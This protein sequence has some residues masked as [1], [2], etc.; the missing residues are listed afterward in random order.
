MMINLNHSLICFVTIVLASISSK[1][2]H[3]WQQDR[4]LINVQQYLAILRSCIAAFSV[5]QQIDVVLLFKLHC[6]DLSSIP[7]A[8]Q[9]STKPTTLLVQHELPSPTLRAQ[10]GGHKQRNATQILSSTSSLE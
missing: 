6:A 9:G 5:M 1:N 10:A 8:S 7:M 3:L 4:C 2:L